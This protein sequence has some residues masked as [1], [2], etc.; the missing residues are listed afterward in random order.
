MYTAARESTNRCVIRKTKY[1]QTLLLTTQYN[2]L[3]SPFSLLSSDYEAFKEAAEQFQPYIKFFATFEKSVSS[4]QTK[5][6]VD[7]YFFLS[8]LSFL[9]QVAKEL[10]LKL[11][12]VDFYE[13]FMEEPVTIPGKPHS[14]E[15]LVEFITEHRR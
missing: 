9:L 8:D 1:N 13:P 2:L 10:T 12:E 7:T 11:N 4:K 6:Q 14:E 5:K 3:F 15:D